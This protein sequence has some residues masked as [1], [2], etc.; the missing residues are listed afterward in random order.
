MQMKEWEGGTHM[1]V[2][3]SGKE[4]ECEPNEKGVSPCVGA[5]REGTRLEGQC[6]KSEPSSVSEECGANSSGKQVI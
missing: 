1:E 4:S 2:A 3:W 6:E 5:G